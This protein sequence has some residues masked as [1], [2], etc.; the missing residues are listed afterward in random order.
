MVKP[1][2]N[3]KLIEASNTENFNLLSQNPQTNKKQQKH[4]QTKHP[5][6]DKKLKP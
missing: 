3:S 5:I 4:K 6:S 2:T 1:A